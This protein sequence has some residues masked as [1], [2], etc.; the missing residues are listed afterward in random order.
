MNSKTEKR[1]RFLVIFI[2]I[3]LFFENVRLFSLFGGVIKVSHVAMI[4]AILYGLIYCKPSRKTFLYFF[5][6]MCI[7][8]LPI[9]RINNINGFLGSYMNYAIIVFF[10]CFALKFLKEAFCKNVSFYLKCFNVVVSVASVLA[11]IQFMMMNFFGI[12]WLD[13]LWGSMQFHP[14]SY[15]I[16]MGFYRAYSVFHEPSYLGFV[17]NASIAINLASPDSMYKST[18][19]KYAYVILYIIATVCTVS[20][21]ALL[22]MGIVLLSFLCTIRIKRNFMLV[23][24]IVLAIFLCGLLIAVMA[25]IDIPMLNMLYERLFNETDRVGTSAYERLKT[26][27]EYIKKTFEYYPFFGRGLGQEGRVDAV[28]IIGRFKGIHN[29]VYGIIVTFGITSVFYYWWFIHS[30]FSAKFKNRNLSGRL[31]LFFATIGMYMSTGSFVSGDTFILTTIIFLIMSSFTIDII[32]EN[33]IE[34]AKK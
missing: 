7:P 29:S 4:L 17:C 25:D 18:T 13:G 24:L 32:N 8:L 33:N 3:S 30:F 26:P 9:S 21:A 28:G 5:F 23:L 14:S 22:I 16:E 11:I 34:S 12:F 1:E 20:T 6:F 27:I 31:L 19:N 2:I 15:G 10:V